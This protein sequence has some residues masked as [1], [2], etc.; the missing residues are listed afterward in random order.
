MLLICALLL[1]YIYKNMEFKKKLPWFVLSMIFL[2]L[3]FDEIFGVHERLI[4]YTRETFNLSG[5]L[6]FSWVLPYGIVTA[7]IAIIY[8]PFLARLPNKIRFLFILAGLIFVL[9]A[10]GIE[11]LGAKHFESFGGD[12]L[13][14]VLYYTLEEFL[15]MIGISIFI[16]AL[17]L[18]ISNNHLSKIAIINLKRV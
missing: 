6:Y 7:F 14:Y 10:I 2:F 12:N 5:Y 11:A 4:G 16:F 13:E 3:S 17:L 9:G 15:E 8:I 1:W 18:Y